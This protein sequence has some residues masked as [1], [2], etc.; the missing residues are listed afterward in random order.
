MAADVVVEVDVGVDATGTEAVYAVSPWPQLAAIEPDSMRAGVETDVGPICRQP[1]V[2][3]HVRVDWQA[4]GAA[5]ALEQA[6]YR[7][8][9]PRAVP[10]LEGETVA[11]VSFEFG[12][13]GFEPLGMNRPVVW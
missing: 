4:E 8:R 12:E 7:V 6:I 10:E 11:R 2:E 3:R 9:E 13:E 1:D 5:S